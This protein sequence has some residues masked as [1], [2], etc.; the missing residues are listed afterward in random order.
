M[1][2]VREAYVLK[3]GGIAVVPK[4]NSITA[5]TET[6]ARFCDAF[7]R[8]TL[9]FVTNREMR[10]GLTVGLVVMLPRAGS[11]SCREINSR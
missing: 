1:S 2:N 4:R 9:R 3:Y 6:L 5:T 7:P 10:H 11:A 8:S